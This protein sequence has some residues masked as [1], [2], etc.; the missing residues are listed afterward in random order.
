MSGKHEKRRQTVRKVLENM[1][2]RDA[3]QKKESVGKHKKASKHWQKHCN[4]RFKEQVAWENSRR[5]RRRKK[6]NT[7]RRFVG[8]NSALSS[9]RG[10]RIAGNNSDKPPGA[11]SNLQDPRKQ[12]KGYVSEFLCFQQ[13]WRKRPL[14]TVDL[15]FN[16]R[17]NPMIWLIKTDSKNKF[18][19]F[20]PGWA[21]LHLGIRL[22]T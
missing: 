8:H 14:L 21:S 6:K 20:W 22:Y 13:K 1:R 19:I 7:L 3:R 10:T 12:Q 9:W 4:W 15:F 18:M 2:H 17:I 16:Y 11:Y 5:C